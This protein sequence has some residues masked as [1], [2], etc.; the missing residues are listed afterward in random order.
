MPKR[1]LVM[2][3]ILFLWA[4][5]V[6]AELL[7]FAA[8]RIDGVKRIDLAAV[9]EV[10]R[11]AAGTA[12]SE[13][14]IDSDLRSIYALGYFRDVEARIE[15]EGEIATLVYRV[16]ERP[17]VR[18]IRTEG[19]KE[20]KSSKLR[21][22]ITIR[23]PGV[24]RA[25][26]LQAS[27]DALRRLYKEEGFYAVEVSNRVEVSDK[28]EATVFFD[29]TEGKKVTIDH[30]E[31][32]GNSAY[33]DRQLRKFI[34]TKQW[35][36]FSW[37]TS[38]GKYNE[39][40]LQNDLM[41]IRDQYFNVGRVRVDVKQP[42]IVLSEDRTKM[43]I[44]IEI[45]E[46][47]EYHV[48]QVDIKGDLLLEKDEMLQ[49]LDFVLG[50]VFSREK[51]R[52]NMDKLDSYYSNRG[53][54]YVNVSPFTLIDD[55]K[56]E[57]SLT[58]DIEQGI[59][60]NIGRINISGNT[61][62]RDKVVRRELTL[63]EGEIYS[64]GRL[65]NSRKR[66]NN[67]GFFSEVNVDSIPR[68]DDPATMDVDVDVKE[69]PTG[70]FS[71]GFGFSSTDGFI[72]QGSV[73]QDNFLG[74][75]LQLNLAA[76]IGGDY[77]NYRIGLLNPYFMDK[78]LALGFDAYRTD[79]EWDEYSIES[80]GGK[81]KL[82]LPLSYETRLFFVYKLEL[83][84]IY[85]ISPYS[86]WYIREQEG[87][88]TISSLYSSISKNTTDFRPDPSRGYMTEF[89]VE[90]A[91]LGGTEKFVKTIADYRHFFPIKWGIVFTPHARIG[92]VSGYNGKNVPL[93]ER[94]FLGGI[95]TIRGFETREVG[96]REPRNY[97]AGYD[98]NNDPIYKLSDNDYDYIGGEKMAYANL[99]VLFPLI[100]D[101][102][103]KGLVFF[104][105]GNAWGEDEDYFSD[106]RYSVGVGIR[107]QSPLGPLRLEWGYNLDPYDYEDK[108]AFDFSI[109][110]FF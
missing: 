30:I 65:E 91:G 3:T 56:K 35:W 76:S 7:T 92:Y 72:G 80:T 99:E 50:E 104:D 60:V 78:N 5:N 105:I 47:P 21:T 22:E 87:K 51:M 37:L 93:N 24:L 15:R 9:K 83:Q 34:Q 102:Q 77:T 54:A 29:I 10:V 8:V 109:G 20:L 17:L 52:K 69:Q 49:E 58:F 71:V 44:F 85:D 66:I 67:L 25:R 31:F 26:D 4:G 46:G 16:D 27:E 89:S 95:N 41:I 18:K 36:I 68:H 13:A 97:F 2:L 45:D 57:V 6:S 84:D 19:N 53:Y 88:S 11:V 70:S 110:K 73:S 32:E 86:S 48:G 81:V 94:F 107:W 14:V 64:S 23:T 63:V 42:H 62:T 74:K 59:Q 101:A 43:D 1:I 55:E 108:S 100:K 79:R 38:G 103:L 106:L 75:A 39:D 33:S 28:N 96:P 82:G 40:M 61:K 12:V 90:V 98:E